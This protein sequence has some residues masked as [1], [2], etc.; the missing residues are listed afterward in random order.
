MQERK[1]LILEKKAWKRHEKL[2]LQNRV[3]YPA[4]LEKGTL[5]DD[6]HDYLTTLL[7]STDQS[8]NKLQY[9]T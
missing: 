7:S 3:Q 2:T 6:T 8:S 4:A 5:S 1:G 9:R